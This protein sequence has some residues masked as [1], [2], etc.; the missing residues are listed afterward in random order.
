M[1]NYKEMRKCNDGIYPAPDFRL[2]ELKNWHFKELLAH[3]IYTEVPKGMSE[4]DVDT[5]WA[6]NQLIDQLNKYYHDNFEHGWLVKVTERIFWD[7][8][9]ISQVVVTVWI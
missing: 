1:T 9:E 4:E 7:G 8:P 6:T 2:F 5:Y 3:W